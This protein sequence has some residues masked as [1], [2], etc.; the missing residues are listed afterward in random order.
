[1][2]SESWVLDGLILSSG[3]FTLMELIADPPRER[4][5]WITAA[6]SE[7]AALFRQP[8]HENRTITMKLRVA[9]QASMDTALDKVGLLVDKLRAASA[10][11]AGLALVWTPTGS[12]RARTF[13]VLTG[14]I[15]GL[16]IALSG[17]GYS[18][19]LQAPIVTVELTCQPYWVGTETLTA[20]AS[21]STPFV[22]QTVTNTGDVPGLGRLIVT[23][24]ATQ[25]RRHVEWGIE[26][27]LTYNAA[28][29]LLIDSDDLVTSGFAG[30]GSTTP[31]G[32]YD[33]NS[34]GNSSVLC[35]LYAGQ[36][37]AVAGTGNLAHTGVFRVKARVYTLTVGTKVRLSWRAG[38]G[39]V[40]ANPW[41]TIGLDS[42][43]VEVDLGMISIDATISGTQRWTGTI[44]A[45]TTAATAS[46][47]VD[48]MVLV[49]AKDG[50]GKARGLY[51]YSSAVTVGYDAFTATTAA[52]A[53]NARVAS[54]GGT[55]ATSG[56][57]TD[58][59]FAD[60]LSGEQVK[61]STNADAS[62][63]FAVLGATSY[64][65]TEVAVD[66][67]HNG[68]PDVSTFFNL[69]AIARWTDSS[70][71][72]TA[73]RKVE[74]DASGTLTRSLVVELVVAGSANVIGTA[75]IDSSVTSSDIYHT[76]RLIAFA[77]GRVI[78]THTTNGVLT[79]T[80]DVRSGFV[81]TG[82]TL[83]TGKVGFMDRST[84]GS[85]VARYYDNFT[86][87]TQPA[88]PMAIYPGRTMQ[89]R[90]D[91]TIRDD[92]TGTYTGRP[93][94]YRGSRFLVPVG[95]SRVLVKAKR[96][97]IDTTAVADDAVTDSTQIAIGYTPRG[98]AV[99]RT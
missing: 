18:W 44:E 7:S 62:R 24:L 41:A 73:Y 54:L 61:R 1:M 14:E 49:P 69:G 38:D 11:P 13:T 8:K 10:T 45:Y 46:F 35:T 66:V 40:S 31:S 9:P 20:T 19:L 27:P 65:D 76:I 63:R 30:T 16:P 89:V 36:T 29:S 51:A 37:I 68:G 71:Y 58:L 2:A 78:A 50:Y 84:S 15:T 70:N 4:Q 90:Y 59:A 26:G 33:P 23:D 56:A 91:D 43:W 98:L 93:S 99:P 83:Q 86:V 67:R 17:D 55:W 3:T 74:A 34:A 12:T 79:A 80:V 96:N 6:D 87:A 25:A 75:T 28:T 53:L 64:T 97:D 48:Y 77:S 39:P 57:A 94:S 42:Q 95:T 88:E 21:S 60:D 72:L 92:S 32:A 47:N 5:D 81:V 22:T 52:A 82:G 85:G